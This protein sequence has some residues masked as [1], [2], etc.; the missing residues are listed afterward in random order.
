MNTTHVMNLKKIMV[1]FDRDFSLSEQLY[2]RHVELIEA[3]N[4]ADMDD[5]FE[6]ALIRCGVR[7]DVLQ[8]ARESEEYEELMDSLRRELTGVIARLDLADQIDR[9]R[10]AA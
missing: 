5:S 10:N 6:R 2:D 8:A 1:N 3:T 4:G 9:A 7:A